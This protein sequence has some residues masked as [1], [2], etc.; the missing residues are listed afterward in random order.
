MRD[1]NHMDSNQFFNKILEHFREN[2]PDDCRK[3]LD[4]ELVL[5]NSLSQLESFKKNMPLIISYSDLNKVKNTEDGILK[6]VETTK[7]LAVLKSLVYHLFYDVYVKLSSPEEKNQ[8]LGVLGYFMTPENNS[9]EK[10][11]ARFSDF[12]KIKKYFKSI[13]SSLDENLFKF[14]MERLSSFKKDQ[15]IK[16]I[17]VM[18]DNILDQCR[19]SR[20]NETVSDLVIPC[21]YTEIATLVS[22]N[23]FKEY[24]D[25]KKAQDYVSFINNIFEIALKDVLCN[26]EK[27]LLVFENL[28][29]ESLRLTLVLKAI[30]HQEFKDIFPDINQSTLSLEESVRLM[31]Q[32]LS[33]MQSKGSLENYYSDLK[34]TYDEKDNFSQFTKLFIENSPELLSQYQ[35]LEESHINNF[36]KENQASFKALCQ[37]SK[38]QYDVENEGN[39]LI[40]FHKSLMENLK[41]E[42]LI[43]MLAQAYDPK[44]TYQDESF[45]KDLI[46]TTT[47]KKLN[48][49]L[50]CMQQFHFQ[51]LTCLVEIAPKQAETPQPTSEPDRIVNKSYRRQPGFVIN[52]DREHL[53]AL[54]RGIEISRMRRTPKTAQKND[55]LTDGGDASVSSPGSS[56]RTPGSNRELADDILMS[57]CSPT[58]F[59]NAPQKRKV[60]PRLFDAPEEQ[61]T[62]KRADLE[63]GSPR[64]SQHSP[65]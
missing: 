54:K 52:V 29:K 51:D 43:K 24:G 19:K 3:L 12:E 22:G 31:R 65:K 39:P 13:E 9:V 59:I 41:L 1:N 48:I 50:P 11:E 40:C 10:V 53:A 35:C 16:N 38:L 14:I 57:P 45:Y 49:L 58:R 15:E 56:A 63:I 8:F 25:K 30:T 7:I 5:S 18:L 36:L 33:D 21:G 6:N 62:P 44:K 46:I 32:H 27:Q 4:L 42:T 64:A 55:N 28:Q 61:V 47:F 17:F 23:V 26:Q 20:K 60:G 2:H 37:L 34:I